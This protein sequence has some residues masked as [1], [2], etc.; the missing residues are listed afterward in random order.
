VLN[1]GAK[2]VGMCSEDA[3]V[4]ST[5][6]KRGVEYHE[7]FHRIFELVIDQKDKEKYR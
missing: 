4:L 2:V 3:V 6:A 5:K 7:A 1:S